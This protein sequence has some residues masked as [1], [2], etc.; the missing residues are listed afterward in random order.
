VD[1]KYNQILWGI[2]Q[3]NKRPEDYLAD[4]PNKEIK[5]ISDIISGQDVSQQYPKN[6]IS[7]YD[8]M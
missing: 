1:A 6:S 4:K 3:K 7:F 8:T 5:R 2:N